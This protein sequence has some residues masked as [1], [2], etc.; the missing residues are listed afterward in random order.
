MYEIV[1]LLHENIISIDI[2]PLW[3][4]IESRSKIEAHSEKEIKKDSM[5]I[6]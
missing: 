3:I 5:E 1:A 2:C 4:S 6:R